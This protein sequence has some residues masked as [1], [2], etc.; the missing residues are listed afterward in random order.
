MHS[1]QLI[2]SA[3]LIISAGTPSASLAASPAFPDQFADFAMEHAAVEAGRL[4]SAC[5][6][7]LVVGREGPRCSEY[8]VAALKLN[9][10]QIA[11]NNWCIQATGTSKAPPAGCMKDWSNRSRWE[12]IE[13]LSR[14][15]DPERWRKI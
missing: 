9:H 4:S 3:V 7:E 12:I 13:A 15:Q 1:I 11:R 5:E 6:S 8:R 2:A 10:L 14:K